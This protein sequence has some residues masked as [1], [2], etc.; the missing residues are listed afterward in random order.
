MNSAENRPVTNIAVMGTS[1]VGKSALT[2]R[3]LTRRFIGEYCNIEAVYT[4][5][6]AATQGDAVLLNIWDCPCREDERRPWASGH[7]SRITWADAFLLVY[8]VCDRDSFNA[9]L[10]MAQAL[11]DARR[12]AGRAARAPAVVVVVGNKRDLQHAR[13]VGTQEAR[14]LTAAL[15]CGFFETSAAE[16]RDDAETVFQALLGAVSGKRRGGGP[17]ACRPPMGKRVLGLRSLL[18]TLSMLFLRK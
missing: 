4:H 2:V 15:G 5:C 10:Q 12:P 11:R 13:A 1:Q 6:V 17:K 7:E 18:K 9:A 3:F 14:A 8:S 16:S